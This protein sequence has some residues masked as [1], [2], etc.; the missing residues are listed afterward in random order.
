[1]GWPLEDLR[2]IYREAQGED[3]SWQLHRHKT[4]DKCPKGGHLHVQE[5]DDK[6]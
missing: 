1:M 3:N 2:K 6:H 4:T 5:F